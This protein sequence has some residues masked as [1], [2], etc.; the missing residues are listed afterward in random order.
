M[1]I[2]LSYEYA[3]KRGGQGQNRT[4]DTSLFRTRFRDS[5]YFAPVKSRFLILHCFKSSYRYKKYERGIF[6][7]D[8]KLKIKW[9]MSKP[10]ISKKDQLNI[11]F[12][13]FLKKY[14]GL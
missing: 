1:I 3:T 9:P 13:E 4:A 7:N 14:K 10:I 12:E 5:G 11:S 6:W 8:Q 2:K